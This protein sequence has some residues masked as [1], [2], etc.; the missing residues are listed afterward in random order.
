MQLVQLTVS[1]AGFFVERHQK[2]KVPRQAVEM[3]KQNDIELPGF[4][5]GE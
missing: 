5:G 1:V 2:L 4:Y 3:F